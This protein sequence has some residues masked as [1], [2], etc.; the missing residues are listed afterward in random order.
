M[1]AN[2]ITYERHGCCQCNVVSVSMILCGFPT[3]SVYI[4]SAMHD[5]CLYPN[6]SYILVNIFC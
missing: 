5:Y 1:T 6:I 3:S 4:E 2:C